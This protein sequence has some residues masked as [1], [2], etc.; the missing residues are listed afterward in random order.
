MTLESAALIQR[1]MRYELHALPC[2]AQARIHPEQ[3]VADMT[4]FQVHALHQALKDVVQVRWRRRCT[5]GVGRKASGVMAWAALRPCQRWFCSSPVPVGTA[6][7]GGEA[8]VSRC[9]RMLTIG[10][11]MRGRGRARR[12]RSRWTRTRTAS[13]P[14]GSSTPGAPARAWTCLHDGTSAV[15]EPS[16]RTHHMSRST[17]HASP[18]PAAHARCCLVCCAPRLAQHSLARRSL[19]ASLRLPARGRSLV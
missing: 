5:V 2:R 6:R 9:S 11:A 16:C 18:T 19:R 14:T 4:E 15:P 8:C 3:P 10:G 13:P 12:R 17:Q 7:G 1:S